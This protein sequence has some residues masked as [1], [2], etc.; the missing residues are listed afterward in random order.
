MKRVPNRS[1]LLCL[2]TTGLLTLL[3][4]CNPF[5]AAWFGLG[6]LVASQFRTTTIEYRC[7]QDGVEVDCS[8][9][10]NPPPSFQ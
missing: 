1:R 4:G 2:L 8:Q 3:A 9:L 6:A 10:S 5:D 7:F